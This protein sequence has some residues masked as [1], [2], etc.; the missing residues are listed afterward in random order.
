MT[1]SDTPRGIPHRRVALAVAA[2]LACTVV[3]VQGASADDPLSRQHQQL[4]QQMKSAQ[5]DMDEAS[6]ALVSAQKALA[7]AQKQLD[8]ANAS[9]AATRAALA[10]AV[11]QDDAMKA[12]LVAA[13]AQL[14]SAQAAVVSARAAM[15]KQRDTIAQFAAATFQT[16]DPQ[17]MQVLTLMQSGSAGEIAD[18][19][20]VINSVIVKQD[21]LY[22]AYRQEL[23]DYNAKEQAVA[24][25][26]AEVAREQEATAAA[27]AQRQTLTAEA[28]KLQASIAGLVKTRADAQAKAAAVQASDQARLAALKKKDDAIQA[29]ILALRRNGANR[30]WSGNGMLLRPVNG[31]ITSPYGWRVHPIYHYWG[32]HDGDDFAANCGTPQVAANSGTVIS[33]YYSD[34]WGNRLYIDLGNINGHNYTV[35]HNHLSRYAVRV[36]QHVKR[37]QVVGY[38]GTTGWSTGCH[39][40][41]TVLRDGNAVDPAPYF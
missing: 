1:R 7:A 33:E 36:G 6:T 14:K 8:A 17:L 22:T 32:L 3:S 11:T 26:T 20:G 16:G 21:S 18:R 9:L 5:A 37:G 31:P 23:A 10:E 4:Q 38:T 2:G 15:E 13:Q 39:L 19:M 40:H 29:Q 24:D 27:V 35:V 25:A 30:S 41:Y 34:V 28:E 12:R